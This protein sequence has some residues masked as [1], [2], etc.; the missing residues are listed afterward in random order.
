MKN[1]YVSPELEIV[2]F[3]LSADVLTVSEGESGTSSGYIIPP[4]DDMEELP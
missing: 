4:E 2:K 3:R 1:K